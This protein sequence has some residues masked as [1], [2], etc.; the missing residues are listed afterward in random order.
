M[1]EKEMKLQ[2][3]I[4]TNM[5]ELFGEILYVPEPEQCTRQNYFM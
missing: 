4:I 1:K 2:S 3:E 5:H